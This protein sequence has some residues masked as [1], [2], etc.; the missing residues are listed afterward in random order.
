MEIEKN[1]SFFIDQQFPDIY[2]QDGPELVALTRYYY[3]FLEETTNQSHHVN[4]RLFD[5][6]DVDSTVKELLVFF[7][8]KF[9]ADLPFKENSVPFLVKNILD[10]Y[11]RKGTP[12]GIETFFSIF[13]N[14][15][16]I[17]ITYPA[18]KML[19]ISNSKWKRGVYLQL[20][21]NNNSFV[22][23]LGK[24]YTYADLISKNI[25]GSVSGA[26]AAVSRINFILIEGTRTPIIYIDA[27]QGNFQKD[28]DVLS[29]IDGELVD[30][31]RVNGS[32]NAFEVDT[33]KDRATNNRV[34]DI[35]NVV[36]DQGRGGK[37]V[38]KG[39][40]DSTSGEISYELIYG[41]YGYSVENTK[42]LVSQQTFILDN[43]GLEFVLY[44]RV[45][46][47]QNNEGIVLGQTENA[48]GIYV[49]NI[50]TIRGGFPIAFENTR[51]IFAIDRDPSNPIDIDLV[52]PYNVSSPGTQYADDGLGTS[53]IADI[54]NTVSISVIT[55]PIQPY[56]TT[57]L[58]AADYG[59]VTPMSGTASPVTITTPLE[60]AFDLTPIT[61]G[62][63]ELFRNIASGENY[64]TQVFARAQDQVIKNLGRKGQIIRFETPADAGVFSIG[65]LITE[66]STGKSAEVNAIDTT[67]GTI[68][69][70][71]F[72]YYGFDGVNDVQKTNG[73]SFSVDAVQTDYESQDYGDNAIVETE[74]EFAIGQ[75]SKV[76]IINSGFGYVANTVGEL[77]DE[78]GNRKAYGI[79]E[80]NTQGFTE[81]Y[82]ADFTSHL[83][84][85]EQQQITIENPILPTSDFVE[86]TQAAIVGE[87]TILPIGN[88]WNI[89]GFQIIFGNNPVNIFPDLAP[90][91]AAWME[92]TASDGYAIYDMTKQGFPLNGPGLIQ[93]QLLASGTAA[94]AVTQRWNEIVAPNLKSQTW[95]AG[96]ED[97]LWIPYQTQYLWDEDFANWGATI[98]SDGFPYLD[99]D[100]DGTI[101]PDDVTIY[102]RIVAGGGTVEQLN[103][104][105]NIVAPSMKQQGFYDLSP[106]LY[107]YVTQ[108]KYFNAGVRIQDSDFY[109][110][111]SY[112]IKSTLPLSMYE[113]TLKE[114]VH[115]AGT[116]LFGDFVYKVEVPNN[117]RTRF[118]RRFND[119]GRG[120]PLDTAN[121]DS[122]EA[123]VT[124]FTVDSS[125]ITVDHEPTS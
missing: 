30:F 14:E 101:T 91:W 87:T 27:V 104:W 56:L 21:S 12:A 25:Q 72:A 125:F 17:D 35:L 16:E 29:S 41:G 115:L 24:K 100:Q 85:Y 8:K 40:S 98:S 120:S 31:G 7:H 61:I 88:V 49:T 18:E 52:T 96:Q 68:S 59:A 65:E 44:E 103:R 48:V 102:E 74:T 80:Q 78:D 23:S 3:K 113:S 94:E 106:E 54:K 97:V 92:S 46:D 73:D 9:L 71:P 32:L 42:L 121:T 108:F 124:N 79:I 63:I 19:K 76:E 86:Q 57:T 47:T 75:I 117:A 37:A 38:V 70:T 5:Y 84:G 122:L 114:N 90:Q 11:R 82:W 1:I 39:L 105:N 50:V 110:D 51:N 66:N 10:L 33:N 2:K 118:F 15:Y 13:Y 34:G 62:R 45:R 111:Y 53:V 43:P 77:Q 99:A 112:L 58:D 107:E 69:I 81:G 55:D 20:Y 109:Q 64:T 26:K 28:D 89:G 22:S 60:D 6:K 36:S 93:F 123:S 67:K 119:D 116:K 4:R 95:Y 83:N